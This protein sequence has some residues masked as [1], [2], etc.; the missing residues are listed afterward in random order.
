[1]D[2][3]QAIDALGGG[4]NA[5]VIVA[6]YMWGRG[7]ENRADVLV[8]TVIEL[9]RSQTQAITELTNEIR[10]GGRVG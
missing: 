10:R 9:G 3:T 8:D 2:W 6:V 5:V 7:R 1:M 4:L